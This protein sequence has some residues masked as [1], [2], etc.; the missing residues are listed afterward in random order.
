MQKDDNNSLTSTPDDVTTAYQVAV[1][2]LTDNQLIGGLCRWSNDAEA[3]MR[4]Q[5]EELRT[6]EPTDRDREL[7]AYWTE[8]RDLQA[9]LANIIRH[10]RAE[11][12]IRCADLVRKYY[13]FGTACVQ[14]IEDG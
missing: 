4:K 1:W 8:R 14:E 7:A 3:C 2:W 6:N 12:R 11:E 5:L 9:W 13:P 10:T